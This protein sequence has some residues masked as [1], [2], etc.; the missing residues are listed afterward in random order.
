MK[1]GILHEFS[2]RVREEFRKRGHDAV[3]CDLIDSEIPG[4]HIKG[5][6]LAQDWSGFDLLICH[7][8]CTY[9]CNSGVRWL[10]EQAG[11]WELM[12]AAAEHFN[13]VLALPVDAIV[14]ENSIMHRHARALIT[15]PYDQ[16]IQPWQ[17]G[18]P[19]TKATCLWLKEVPPLVPT[20]IMAERKARAHRESPGPDR[21]KRRSRTPIGVAR[22]MAEQWG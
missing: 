9:L 7:P 3:L 11:R 2:A 4:P 18:E 20:R 16:I 12:R 10:H 22:A 8:P 21:W 1:V 19:E 14:V 17:Y 13:A 5:D 6:C 15:R